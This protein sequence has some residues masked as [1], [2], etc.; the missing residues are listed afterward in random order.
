[1]RFLLVVLIPV[2]WLVE[3]DADKFAVKLVG[4]EY[5]KSA[6]LKL[7][8]ADRFEEPSE[9]HPSA[10]ERVKRIDKLDALADLIL[11]IKGEIKQVGLTTEQL[12]RSIIRRWYIYHGVSGQLLTAKGIGGEQ[13]ANYGKRAMDRLTK[14]QRKAFIDALR[15]V[16]IEE[17]YANEISV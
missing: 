14:E 13:G 10:A 12:V 9:T 5:I 2:N 17:G 6:L 8:D 3:F 15:V 7:V 11:K 1:L 4:K 16:L